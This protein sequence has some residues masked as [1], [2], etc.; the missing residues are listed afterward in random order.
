MMFLRAQQT[1]FN[2]ILISR[3]HVFLNEVYDALGIDRTEAGAIVGWVIGGG[4]NKIDFGIF[5]GENPRTRAFVN[6]YEHS[7]LLDFNV[8]GV[9]YDLFTKGKA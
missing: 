6:G 4:D 3:G 1:Y 2:N 7:I 9:I 8:D 5:D